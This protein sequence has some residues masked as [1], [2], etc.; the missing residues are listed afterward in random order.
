M[1]RK[2]D[3]IIPKEFYKVS[4]NDFEWK[5]CLVCGAEVMQL[6][7]AFFECINCRMSYIADEEDM[8]R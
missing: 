6:R 7:K 4:G 5:S 1:N 3:F 8:R 2:E